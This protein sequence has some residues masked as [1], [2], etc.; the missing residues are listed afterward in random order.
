MK[1]KALIGLTAATVLL[2]LTA[3]APSAASPTLSPV[4]SIEQAV[5][6][7]SKSRG[8]ASGGGGDAAKVGDR[9][10]DLGS[11]WAI[12]LTI[13]LAGVLLTVALVSRNI[14][15]AVGVV[16]VSVIALIFFGDPDS[17]SDFAESV[18]SAIF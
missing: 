4:E 8:E 13:F 3:I 10:A 18:G 12:P 16:L 1:P 17:I 9:A 14:G 15:G 6:Q 2:G 7:A 11:G 5:A